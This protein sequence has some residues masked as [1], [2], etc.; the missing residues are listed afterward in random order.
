MAAATASTTTGVAVLDKLAALEAARKAERERKREDAK[1]LA[2]PKESIEAF[3]AAFQELQ[4]SVSSRLQALLAAGPQEDGKATQRAL[5]ELSAELLVLQGRTATASYFLPSYDQKQCTG[6]I[7]DM[8]QAIDNA[9]GVLIPKKKFS[10][11]KKVSRVKGSDVAADTSASASAAEPGSGALCSISS[12]ATANVPEPST[13]G[14]SPTERDIQL[15]KSGRG[16]MGARGQAITIAAEHLAGGEFV[17]LDLQDCTVHLAGHTTSVRLFNLRNTTVVTGP[18]TGSC[19]VH[20]AAGCKLHLAAYQVRIHNTSD[21][22]FYLRVRSKP[23]IEHTSGVHFAPYDADTQL[24]HLAPLV[25]AHQLGS[26]E[27]DMWSQVDDFGWIKATQSPNWAVLPP[28]QR[29]PA[30]AMSSSLA[31]A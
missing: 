8:R 26:G 18:I 4:A 6:R 27:A 10:F 13:A 5:D 21:T 23:I 28:E 9:Q 2:D 15:A 22:H 20:H 31:A 29:L 12:Q 19:F 17:L 16:I 24:T 30:P 11:S 1:E 14:A 3:L 25:A 7:A